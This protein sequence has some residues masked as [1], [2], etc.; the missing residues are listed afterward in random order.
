MTIAP[1]K[2]VVPAVTVCTMLTVNQDHFRVVQDEIIAW[3]AEEED[4]TNAGFFFGSLAKQQKAER[5][6]PEFELNQAYLVTRVRRILVAI[7][8]L[9][10]SMA[11]SRLRLV[12]TVGIL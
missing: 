4:G 2:S 6:K 7:K 11:A 10:S 12:K 5:K 3:V 1:K 8:D 9:P